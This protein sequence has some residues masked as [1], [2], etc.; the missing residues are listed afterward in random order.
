MRKVMI[1]AVLVVVAAGLGV[2]AESP[3]QTAVMK[4]VNQFV[5][6]FNKA[7]SRATLATCGHQTSIIDEFPP[8]T[9]QACSAWLNDYNAWAKKNGV[10]QGLVTLGD[11]RHV[12]ITGNR[13]Y[14]VVPT[15]FMFMQNGTPMKEEGSTLTLV[16]QKSP[17]GWRITAWTWT[18]G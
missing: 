14:V 10:T 9:W 18:M 17:A 16:L 13:A 3:E 2:A 15:S 11:P 7:D 5:G 6:G 8:H 12:D 4:T 1:V